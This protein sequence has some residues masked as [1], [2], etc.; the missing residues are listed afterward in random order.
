MSSEMMVFEH[1][2]P[3]RLQISITGDLAAKNQKNYFYIVTLMS[4]NFSPRLRC[5]ECK[6]LN[7]ADSPT[8]TS[9]I[10]K[11]HVLRVRIMYFNFNYFVATLAR[12][13]LNSTGNTQTGQ[14]SK[15]RSHNTPYIQIYLTFVQVTVHIHISSHSFVCSHFEHTSQQIFTQFM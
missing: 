2:L 7:H 12:I 3:L 13:R 14:S 6:H 15:T 1:L 10:I 5:P 8:H 4:S 11:M 9:G